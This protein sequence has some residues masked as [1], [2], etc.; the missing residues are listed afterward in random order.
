MRYLIPS[1]WTWLVLAGCGA[2]LPAPPPPPEVTVAQVRSEEM[3]EW[4]EYQ[5]V[6]QAVDR[7]D[8]RPRVSGYLIRVAFTEGTEVRKG[9]VLFEIDPEPYQA[10]LDERKADLTRAQARLSLTERDAQRG[11]RLAAAQAISQE[12]QDT[13]LTLVSEAKA[14]VA[15]AEAAV[16]AAELDLGFT[17]VRSPVNGRT[18]RAEVTAGNLVSSGPGEATELT[19]IVSLDPIYVYFEG[20]ESAY[21]RYA[22]LDRTGERASSRRAANPVQ[23]GLA[24]EEGFPHRGRMDFVDNRLDR[25]TGTI[26]A[27][28]VVPNRDRLFTPGMFARVRLIGSGVRRVTVIP[29]VAV[30][31][32]QDR[33]FVFVLHPDSSTVA[34]RAVVL[35]R[36]VDGQ[37]RIIRDGLNPG[38]QV[39][40]NGFARIR[41]G[42]RVKATVAP[43]D[44]AAPAPVESGSA[45]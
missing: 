18:S 6:F 27:R 38:E 31:T 25:E 41:P 14:E 11:E 3:A 9:D 34:Y 42:V 24:D 35:G 12:E 7:V 44:S 33:K 22:H 26:R 13:R 36:Q 16:R 21:L 2:D 10:T 23:I 45:P 5:G 15:A 1:S 43:P 39:V 4:D 30:S 8:V 28:A 40:V 19:T 20:D 17:K 37:R 29:E 32:D